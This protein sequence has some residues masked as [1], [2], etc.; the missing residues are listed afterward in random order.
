M[1]GD[2]GIKGREERATLATKSHVGDAEVGHGSDASIRRDDRYLRHI[3]M[4]AN[5][6]A[7]KEFRKRKMPDCLAL[8]RDDI[9]ILLKAE[10][11]LLSELSDGFGCEFTELYV[12][13]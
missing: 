7:I 6:V 8:A 5:L 3:Q 9:N 1:R 2:Q 12:F 10:A 11:L 4:R 13:R